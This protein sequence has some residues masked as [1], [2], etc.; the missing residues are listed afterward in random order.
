V[1]ERSIIDTLSF[2]AGEVILYPGR[3]GPRDRIYRVESG[4]VRIQSVDNDGNALTLRFVKEG[5]YFGEEALTGEKRSYHAEAAVDTRIAQVS[6]A[7][8]TPE[9]TLEIAGHLVEA[10]SQA[11]D[12]I[13]RLTTQRLRHRVARAMLELADTPLAFRDSRGRITI[14]ATHDEIAAAVGSVRETVTKIIGELT[15]EGVIKSGY[16]RI[17]LLDLQTLRELADSRGPA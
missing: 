6:T 12:A 7:N 3:V 11:Y 16:G 2:R 15:R 1:S 14:R 4:L 10:L 5:G 13:H 9:E 17:L 8:L